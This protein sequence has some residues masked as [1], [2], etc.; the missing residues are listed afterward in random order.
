MHTL[1]KNGRKEKPT[2]ISQKKEEK[3]KQECNFS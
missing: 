3:K 1:T 2:T